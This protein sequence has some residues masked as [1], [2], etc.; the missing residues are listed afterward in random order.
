MKQKR[1]PKRQQLVSPAAFARYVMR[2]EWKPQPKKEL[3]SM[4][5]DADV[6]EWFRALGEGYQSRIN[7]LL[8][9]Y[10]EAHQ[11]RRPRT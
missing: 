9:A 11:R 7:A 10:M 6:L 5:I 8:R 1:P 2:N 3:F 4:R